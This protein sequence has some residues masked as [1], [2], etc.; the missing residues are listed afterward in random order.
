MLV[1]ERPRLAYVVE[2]G[3]LA[4]DGEVPLAHVGIV[5]DALDDYQ[6][7]LEDV[8]V[9]ELGLLLDV[10]RLHELGHDVGHEPEAHERPQA[11]RDVLREQD[12]LELVPDALCARCSP[13]S[14]RSP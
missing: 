10:H 2:E 14:G 8:L 13:A 3:G 5:S 1:D 6:G 11:P 12:L 9:V 7:V 4:Q